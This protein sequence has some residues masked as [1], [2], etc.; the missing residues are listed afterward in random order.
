MGLKIAI[1]GKG[2]VGKT[3]FAGLLCRVLAKKGMRVIG[4]DADP[5]ANLQAALGIDEEEQIIPLSQ[6]GDLISERTGAKKGEI[7][8][9]FKMN[10][11]VDDLPETLSR[12][13]EGVKLLVM[14]TVDH[15][16]AGCVCPEAVILKALLTHL[17]LYRDDVVVMD[18]EAGVEHLGRATTA[19]MDRL[20][21]VVN[22]GRR[23]QV[24]AK[25][26]RDLAK[27]IGLA[28]KISLIG[29]RVRGE[30]D[31]Q[32]LRETMPD[33]D[34]LGFVEET[35]EIA[36]AD[37]DARMPFE[38]VEGAPASILAI[39]DKLIELAQKPETP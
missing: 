25:Q 15:G 7:G 21:I 6:L 33:F 11:K 23:S 28:N 36:Q 5:V 35:E 8:G 9:F 30:A 1:S 29:N 39:A 32:R 10:P 16:G 17:V 19:R 22:P 26:I 31:I 18:M 4:I 12:E 24:A 34:F 38:K 37:M 14:G 20:L 2:G 27:D 3:T 13:A